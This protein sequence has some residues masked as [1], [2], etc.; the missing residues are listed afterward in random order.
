[1]LVLSEAW[2]GKLEEGTDSLSASVRAWLDRAP[3]AVLLCACVSRS[4]RALLDFIART[5]VI[6]KNNRNYIDLKDSKK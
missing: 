1:M 3:R 6:T 4:R 5:A 2:K